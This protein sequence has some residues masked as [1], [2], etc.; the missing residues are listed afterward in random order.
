MPVLLT[1]LSICLY[2]YDSFIFAEEEADEEADECVHEILMQE[3]QSATE[4]GILCHYLYLAS[5]DLNHT[6]MLF[7]CRMLGEL[8]SSWYIDTAFWSWALRFHAFVYEICLLWYMRRSLIGIRFNFCQSLHDSYPLERTSGTW[9]SVFLHL[10]Q[11]F[12]SGNLWQ[13]KP[14]KADNAKKE[15][16]R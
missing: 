16:N 12:T 11:S 10:I 3:G 2:F 5:V 13:E 9:V 7:C 4:E 8:H 1:R 14:T 15:I 6:L